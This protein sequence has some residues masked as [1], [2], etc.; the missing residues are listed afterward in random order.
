MEF[1][2]R[3]GN[4]LNHTLKAENKPV[5]IKSPDSNTTYSN[6]GTIQYFR[7]PQGSGS[8]LLLHIIYLFQPSILNPSLY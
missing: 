8:L 6:W 1:E 2:V 4:S 7:V 3:L 5:E